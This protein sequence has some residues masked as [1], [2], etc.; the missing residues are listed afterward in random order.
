MPRS[1]PTRASPITTSNKG[2]AYA[3]ITNTPERSI[4]DVETYK[5][6]YRQVL[7]ANQ[8]KRADPR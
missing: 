6:V 3:N 1:R 5:A 4:A 7:N 8:K 2:A